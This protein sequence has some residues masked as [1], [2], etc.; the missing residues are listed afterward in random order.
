[1]GN[2]VDPSPMEQERELERDKLSE[3]LSVLD[4]VEIKGTSHHSYMQT[5]FRKESCE[6]Q[7]S[8]TKKYAEL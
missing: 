3:L 4:Q 2:P 1:M 7:I 8:I 5:L 6:V